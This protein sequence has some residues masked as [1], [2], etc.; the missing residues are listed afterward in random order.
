MTCASLGQ[1]SRNQARSHRC[2]AVPPTLDIA[3][4]CHTHRL[5]FTCGLLAPA[6]VD[7][8][9]VFA[10]DPK[11]LAPGRCSSV[12]KRT[13]RM[14]LHVD[15]IH[16]CGLIGLS[17]AFEVWVVAETAQVPVRAKPRAARHKKRPQHAARVGRLPESGW[18]QILFRIRQS[19]PTP[20]HLC[21]RCVASC[22]AA[23]PQAAVS[24][25]AAGVSVSLA[26]TRG[27][28]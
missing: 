18:L 14:T 11:H 2:C 20:R 7:K 6:A 25:H 24:F 27:S 16:R 19:A 23:S 22:S 3:L 1:Q 15:V 26:P 5:V 21:R 8:D 9:A 4:F 17:R 28:R 10:S 13:I 12:K